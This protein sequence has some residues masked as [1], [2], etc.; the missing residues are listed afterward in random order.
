MKDYHENEE[1]SC[2]QY[3]DV[4]NLQK[5]KDKGKKILLNVVKIS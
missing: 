5:I 1:S 2:L 4:N 3:L